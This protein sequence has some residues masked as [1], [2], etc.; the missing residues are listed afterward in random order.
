MYFLEFL[1]L[2][3]EREFI[4]MK[5]LFSG[6]EDSGKSLRMAIEMV[7]VA[8]RNAKWI[9]MGLPPRPIYS[10]LPVRQAFKDLCAEL[11]VPFVDWSESVTVVE[12][13]EKLVSCDL[14]L[15]ETGTYFDSRTFAM[16]PLSTRLWLAQASK[17]GVDIYGTCQDVAQIDISFRRLKPHVTEVTKIIGS[18]RPDK[19]RPPVNRIWGICM[20]K[21][22][23]PLEY[24]DKGTY[25]GT[26]SFP[27]F[28]FITKAACSIY[29]TNKRVPKAEIP[30][31]K[32]QIRRCEDPS[33]NFEL[34]KTIQGVKH[35]V[36]HV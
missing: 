19:T 32:H 23:S 27:S 35:K 3:A 15:D 33:C 11:N 6:A 16:L 30:P 1:V 8:Y 21:E 13:L 28:F 24:D 26:R 25:S 31:F 18:P 9:N 10:V 5:W 29:D 17:L 2:Y 22:L 4:D 12:E 20:T 7:D 36:V 34:Y 14:F